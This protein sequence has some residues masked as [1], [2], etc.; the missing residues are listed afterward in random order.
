M[1]ILD[2][3]RKEL[4]STL[5]VEIWEGLNSANG[6]G[7]TLP[8]ML[9]YDEKGL[10]LYEE[11]TYLDEYYLTNTEIEILTE[12]AS[13]MAQT[14]EPGT[15]LVELGSGYVNCCGVQTR[16][17]VVGTNGVLSGSSGLHFV[18]QNAC[19]RY[20]RWLRDYHL[21]SAR[22][23]Q[24]AA[25]TKVPRLT[26]FAHMMGSGSSDTQM[27]LHSSILLLYAFFLR[28]LSASLPIFGYAPD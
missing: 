16:S 13:A 26:P 24:Q 28:C 14:I 9:L 12:H 6:T 17:N 21:E 1:A 2:I 22:R 15:K 3:R 19:R 7:K 11:I 23:S 25:S 20:N 5:A 4:A 10:Q 27:Q 8:T 18:P